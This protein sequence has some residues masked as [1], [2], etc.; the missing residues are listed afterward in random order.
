VSEE[1]CYLIFAD[2][3]LFMQV[4]FVV[5]VVLG[6]L[7]ICAGGLRNWSWVRNLWFRLAH[8]L[9]VGIVVLQSW[10][11]MLCPLTVWEVALREKAGDVVYTGS[12]VAHWLE[13]LLYY[14]A[15]DWIF[16]VVYTVFGMLVIASW[17]F[18]R[19]HR[20]GVSS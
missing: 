5:F 4:V 18:V 19:P 7:L 2:A 17:F 1:L 8:L 10:L 14:R 15:P 9:S 16:V 3:M 12:F 11:G 20:P 13:S 6:L